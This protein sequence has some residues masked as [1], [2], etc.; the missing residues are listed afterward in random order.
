MLP[1]FFSPTVLGNRGA[2]AGA[3]SGVIMPCF[4]VALTC[5]PAAVAGE[6][7]DLLALAFG[8][9]SACFQAILHL[10]LLAHIARP[11]DAAQ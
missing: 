4:M 3:S 2:F 6:V 5:T 7:A 1:P 11:A 10:H 8:A 9:C